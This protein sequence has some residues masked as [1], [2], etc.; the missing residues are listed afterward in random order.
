MREILPRCPPQNGWDLWQQASLARRAGSMYLS[1]HLPWHYNLMNG[2]IDRPR[3]HSGG[4]RR[5]APLV[6]S[7]AL[8][9]RPS[10]PP[11]PPPHRPP[12]PAVYHQAKLVNDYFRGGWT[13]EWE[14]TGGPTLFSG[15]QSAAVD[16]GTMR[17]M[18]LGYLAAGMKARGAGT[19]GG[20]VR[21]GGYLVAGIKARAPAPR[22]PPPL[23]VAPHSIALLSAGRRAVG[24]ERPRA[25][26]GGGR[27]PARRHAGAVSSGG[28]R[29]EGGG[30][31]GGGCQ[32]LGFRP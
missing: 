3:A 12:P 4:R 19:M 18:L 25:R 14:S 5:G 26:P 2:E 20:E 8:T 23:V 31:V 1:L 28:G 11:P 13:G 30:G 6:I 16:A 17:R 27:V 9:Y 7:C 29:S 24:V 15:G 32:G 10:N 22:P 21:R